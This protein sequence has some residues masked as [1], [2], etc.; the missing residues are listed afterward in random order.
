MLIEKNQ[1]FNIYNEPFELLINHIVHLT[2]SEVGYL[3]LYNEETEEIR[4][5]VWSDQVINQ[6]QLIH[7]SHYPLKDAGVWADCIRTRQV[8]FHNDYGRVMNNLPEGHFPVASHM[9]VP[10]FQDKAIVGIIGIGNRPSSYTPK[11]AAL[12]AQIAETEWPAIKAAADQI[13]SSERHEE[14][15]HSSA[16]QVLEQMIEAISRALELRDAYTAEHQSN[17]AFICEQIACQM[18]IPSHIREGLKI[19]ALVHD[20]GKITIPSQILG[21]PGALMPEE[22][23]LLKH[24]AEAGADIFSKVDCPWPLEDMIA[25][26]HERLDGSGYPNQLLG[27]MI[28]MEARIIAVADTFDAMSSDRPYRHSLG[29]KFAL[30]TILEG[31][32]TTYDKYVVAAFLQCFQNDPTF[33]GRYKAD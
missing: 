5:A 28:C 32:D 25:Q 1:R 29:A 17:V 33:E 2:G 31:A 22:F 23:A 19:G 26:H 8:V 9:S 24:H 15:S 11:D 30:E 27:E 6:C 4:L 21:K 18:G 7:A 12:V 13:Y 16:M 14:F 10:V 3:H 20:I